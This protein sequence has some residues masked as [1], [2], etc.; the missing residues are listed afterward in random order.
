[1]NQ[2]VASIRLGLYIVLLSLFFGVGLGVVFGVAEDGVQ[3]W[4]K[5]GVAQHPTLHDDKSTAKIWRYAQ[6]AHFHSMGVAA[7]AAGLLGILALTGMRRKIK[8]VTSLLIGLGCL[9]PMSW[10]SMFLLAPSM[11]RE[12]AHHALITELFTRVGVG[13]LLL[14]MVLLGV[15]LV[16]GVLGDTSE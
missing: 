13:A 9:Y 12:A 16:T 5:E 1:M 6:R 7:A 4:I 11:G 10:F 2:Q 15:H 8:T 3:D 14:G